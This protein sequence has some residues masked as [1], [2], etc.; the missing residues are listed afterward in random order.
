MTNRRSLSVSSSPIGHFHSSFAPFF[1]V[2]SPPSC[3]LIVVLI[4]GREREKPCPV[5]NFSFCFYFWL[6][7][8]YI[9]SRVLLR[10]APTSGQALTQILQ[11]MIRT[12]PVLCVYTSHRNDGVGRP[13]I[14]GHRTPSWWFN[15]MAHFRPYSIYLIVLHTSVLP[16]NPP[17]RAHFS[18]NFHPN[19][20]ID[21]DTQQSSAP[22][23]VHMGKKQWGETILFTTGTK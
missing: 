10:S 20:Q 15:F 16:L 14:Y 21:A 5:Q 7:K 11:L 2:F 6:K 3:V 9:S 18:F 4:A 12:G 1:F 19:S 13:Y 22:G 17:P 8:C 23:P